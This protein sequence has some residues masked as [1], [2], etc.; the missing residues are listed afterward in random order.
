MGQPVSAVREMS[1]YSF[2]DDAPEQSVQHC[3]GMGTTASS[4]A[5]AAASVRMCVETRT[6][7]SAGDT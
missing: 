7:K 1:E 2:L 3:S 4:I 6:P 5:G